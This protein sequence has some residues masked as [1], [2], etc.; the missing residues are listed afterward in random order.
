MDAAVTVPY[1]EY[2]MDEYLYDTFAD[3]PM[4]GTDMLGEMNPTNDAH[5]ID[6]GSF[7]STVKLP[8]GGKYKKNWNISKTGSLNPYVNA[9]EVMRTAWNNNPSEYIGRHNS[10]YGYSEYSSAP[11]CSTFQICF[12]TSSYTDISYCL[13]GGTHGPVHIMIGGAW[14]DDEV[15]GDPSVSFLKDS[16]KILFFKVLWRMGLTRCPESC[17]LNAFEHCRCSVP[18]EYLQQHGPEGILRLSN[19]AYSLT[20]DLYGGT[21]ETYLTVLRAVEHPGVAGEMFTS[22]ATFDPTFW[23]LHGTIERMLGYKRIL[24]SLGEDEF[25]ETWGYP[26]Y[27]PSG[28]APFL[29]GTCDWSNVKS[30]SDLTLPLC[31][32]SASCYGHGEHDTLDFSNFLNVGETYSNREFYNFIHPWN[33]ELP[34]IYDDYTFDYCADEGYDFLDGR[35]PT[36]KKAAHR[37]RKPTLLRKKSQLNI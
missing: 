12:Q 28:S 26:A 1:W 25:D 32:F 13:N 18:D 16:D 15:M 7:W 3:D 21:N 5:R 11:S 8:D 9:F 2:S 10:T 22:A 14:A 31:N 33:G 6:D 30:V 24:V 23:P 27:D 20:S 37:S 19:I 29:P 4:F 34:Y 36:V 35:K 17:D